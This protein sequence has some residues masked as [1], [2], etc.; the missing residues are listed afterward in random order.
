[1]KEIV[2]S[3]L[4]SYMTVFAERV[5]PAVFYVDDMQGSDHA[6]GNSPAAAWKSLTQVNR[7]NI[8]PGDRVLFKCG[9]LWRGQLVP[10][11]GSKDKRVVYSSYGSGG[12][13]IIQGSLSYSR[14][15]CWVQTSPGIWSTSA[16]DTR[17]IKI[18]MDLHASKWHISFQETA[19]GTFEK[20]TVE[21]KSFYRIKCEKPGG[22]RN[23]IQLWGP[24]I[25]SSA[26]VL[27]L[28][29]R[30][31][32]TQPFE[33]KESEAMLNHHPWTVAYKGYAPKN[34]IGSQWQD[35]TLNLQRQNG[36]IKSA[37]HFHLGDIMPEGAQVDI[38]PLVLYEALYTAG[39]PIPCD[40]G[41]LIMDHGKAWG[42]KKWELK[43]L[44]RPLDYW[45]DASL[46]QLH[47]KS[48]KNPALVY[49]SVELALKKHIVDQNR[50]HDVTYDGLAVRYGAAH[51]F[52]GCNTKNI[53][54]RNCDVYW[55]GGGLQFF[56]A[57]GYPVRYGNGIEFW[58]SAE[59]NLVENNRIWEIYDAALTNQGNGSGEDVSQ[60]VNI[61]YRNNTIWNAEYSFEYWNRPVS[62]VTQN[63]LFEHNTC[64]DAGYG[65]A[66]DQR[67]DKNGAHLMF[68]HNSAE[69]SDFVV[70][71][72]IFVNST[73]VITRMVNDWRTGLVMHNNL[74]F[75]GEKPIVR[76][77]SKNYYEKDDFNKYQ[78]ELNLDTKSIFAKPEFV[79]SSERDYALVSGSAGSSLAFDGGDV[80]ARPAH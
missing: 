73:E 22:R 35:L 30:I 3:L 9:G 46:F 45:Y 42:V 54:I 2:T 60:Q 48:E 10:K 41:I 75:Q 14:E 27:Q 24:M 57:S 62:A 15:E 66:H 5:T 36:I 58:N 59:N 72:N 38:E 64:V 20:I 32:S 49:K 37:L 11:N 69:T 6:A 34:R 4:L 61:I 17:P 39:E 1:M 23:W 76:W 65:W 79:K 63:I 33:I 78:S 53:T 26:K 21:G 18:L 29:V 13:P 51:G 31:R 74:I 70:R 19:K 47:V 56:N 8:I 12:K 67:P 55:I 44:T 52:G 40:V 25:K 43:E 16:P 68:Y 80:G 77:L 71:N 7:A 28:K 50:R